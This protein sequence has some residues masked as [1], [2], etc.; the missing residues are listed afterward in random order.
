MEQFLSTSTLMIRSYRPSDFDAV[1][2]LFCDTVRSVNSKDYSEEQINAWAGCAD[3][4]RW[5]EALLSNYALVAVANGVVVGFGDIDDNGY[6][7]HLYVHKDFLRRK[8]ASRLC[9]RLEDYASRHKKSVTA[10]ASITALPF[11]VRRGY[12]VIC[13]NAVKR[14][15]VILK[16]YTVEKKL[17]E[18]Q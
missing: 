8:I 2:G 12:N 15:G 9:K 5:N 18:E 16:N 13:E 3:F 1:V 6:L 17:P 14:G 11:F 4:A 7:D 10:H